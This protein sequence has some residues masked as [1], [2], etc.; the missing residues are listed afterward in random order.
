MVE[1]SVL[2][3]QHRR[4]PRRDW[5]LPAFNDLLWNQPVRDPTNDKFLNATTDLVLGWNVAGNLEQVV[6]QEWH[7]AFYRMGHFRPISKSAQDHMKQVRDE[8]SILKLYDMG[9]AGG[10]F[11]VAPELLR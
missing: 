8:S 4:H 9:P 3:T 11:G 10:L 7:S 6:I 5:P 1:S 2:A